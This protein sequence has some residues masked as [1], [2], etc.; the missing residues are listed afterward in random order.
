VVRQPNWG[1]QDQRL[2]R[3]SGDWESTNI[4]SKFISRTDPYLPGNP[5]A[6]AH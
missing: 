5:T 1:F 6:F 3:K 2:T 4:G